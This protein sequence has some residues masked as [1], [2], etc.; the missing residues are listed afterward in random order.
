[1]PKASKA[2]GAQTA[3]EVAQRRDRKGYKSG[4]AGAAKLVVVAAYSFWHLEVPF[5]VQHS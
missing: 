3:Q 1:M 4:L 2:G 5:A